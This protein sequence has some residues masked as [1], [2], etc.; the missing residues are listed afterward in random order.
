MVGVDTDE[1]EDEG[2]D[3]LVGMDVASLGVAS[4]PSTWRDRKDEVDWGKAGAVI[5]GVAG[6]EEDSGA[7]A[8]ELVLSGLDDKGNAALH[9]L[10]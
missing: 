5:R 9:L 10:R 4:G 2:R 6:E 3:E 7:I 8:T 1:D